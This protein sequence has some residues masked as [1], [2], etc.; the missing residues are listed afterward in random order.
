MALSHPDPAPDSASAALVASHAPYLLTTY[1]RPPLVFVRGQGPY[2]WDLE[3]RYVLSLYAIDPRKY[4]DFMAGI[5][6]V[7]LGHADPTLAQLMYDQALQLT[8]CS[9]L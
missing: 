5:A 6:V 4:I 1:S 8:H 9:N 3:N 2:L 7:A